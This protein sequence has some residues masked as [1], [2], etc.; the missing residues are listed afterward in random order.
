MRLLGRVLR[1]LRPKHVRLVYHPGYAQ[2]IPRIPLDPERG[3]RILAFLREERLLGRRALAQPQP[4]S[5]QQMLRV[6]AASYVASLDDVAVVSHAIGVPVTEAER[7]RTLEHQRLVT[8]GTVLAV[9]QALESGDRVVN[10]G[11]GLHHATPT[12][13]MGFCLI[14]DVAIA[15]AD[16]RERGFHRPVLVVDLDLHDGNGTR[17]AFREDAS[18]HT[19]SVHNQ[20]WEPQGGEATTAVALGSGVGDEQLLTVLRETLPSVMTAVRPGLVMY[21]AG[22]DAAEDD[23]LGDW[24]MTAA[25]LLARDR[26][27]VECTQQ[28][29][30]APPFVV[31][32]A[33]GY[34][35]DAWRY[36]ARFVGWLAGGTVLDPP[37]TLELALRA[38]RMAGAKTTDVDD[39]GLTEADL[40]AVVPG[41]GPPPRVLGALSRLAIEMS[42]EEVGILDR[43]RA[44]GF[45]N[46]AIEVAYGG[47][48]GDT[49]RLLGEDSTAD[50]LMELRVS[51]NRRVLP[52]MEL[53][54]VEWLRLQNPRLPFG[55]TQ[56]QLPGQDHPGLGLLREIVAWIVLLAERL[57]LDGVASTSS[58]YYMAVLGRH[59]LQ[60]MDQAGQARFEALYELLG[61]MRLA[62]A[63]RALAEGRVTD[64][65][66]GR[67]VRWEPAVTVLPV[68]KR[69]RER[70]ATVRKAPV[71]SP[72]FRLSAG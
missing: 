9:R 38:Y 20:H 71:T 37:D 17:A 4:V 64:A 8:G 35:G 5:L 24:R 40:F 68:S 21:V 47:D 49:I 63:E 33:G 55:V 60:F 31:V 25:G 29:D 2:T 10:L 43:V 32:L 54:Y 44:L 46:P 23:R 15:I 58:Q 53:L 7:Q 70:L 62:D 36:S 67:P 59:H 16:A 13:G 19:L 51:R 56:P 39:W 52:G 27:V 61:G 18:V 34:G 69:L 65:E 66:T 57:H 26:F 1:H 28:L 14:N 48:V 6:H 41:A 12:Q 3:E 11:G 22:T 45:A 50:V 42:L 72:V 30:P